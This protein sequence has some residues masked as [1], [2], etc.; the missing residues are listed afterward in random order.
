MKIWLL[1]SQPPTGAG[2]RVEITFQPQVYPLPAY[3]EA[4]VAGVLVAI[5]HI[6]AC[7]SQF[8]ERLEPS[9]SEIQARPAFPLPPVTIIMVDSSFR[10]WLWQTVSDIKIL[11]LRS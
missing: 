6:P 3:W 4:N 10:H 2:N 11:L 8:F 7:T 1:I 5:C 9:N